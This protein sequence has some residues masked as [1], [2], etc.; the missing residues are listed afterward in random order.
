MLCNVQVQSAG[1]AFRTQL[2]P[3]S[4]LTQPTAI[5]DYYKYIFGYT[6]GQ[7]QNGINSKGK[8]HCPNH[9]LLL[10]MQ[11]QTLIITIKKL[12]NLIGYQ[13]P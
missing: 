6:Q 12:S 9:W 11:F 3:K 4:F 8:Q 7:L 2:V 1:L 13:L 10:I 5:R